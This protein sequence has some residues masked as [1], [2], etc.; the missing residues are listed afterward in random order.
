[1]SKYNMCALTFIDGQIHNKSIKT[2]THTYTPIREN[3]FTY[4]T[5]IG[6]LFATRLDDVSTSSLFC[7]KL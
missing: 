7:I 6:E 5:L 2:K 4:F 3:Y 1:M